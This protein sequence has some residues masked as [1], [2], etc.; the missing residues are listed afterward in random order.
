MDGTSHD[1]NLT[2]QGSNDG[3]VLDIA[4]LNQSA[5]QDTAFSYQVPANTFSDLDGDA[6]AYS[7]SLADGSSLPAWLGF[8]ASTGTLSG[9]PANSDVGS[10]SV[11]V[12]ASDGLASASSTFTL[13]VNNV[14]DVAV[15]SGTD[16]GAVTEDSAPSL[17]VSGTLNISD[18]DVGESQFN[19]GNYSGLYGSVTLDAAGAWSY[20]ASSSQAAIQALGDG[21]TLMDTITIQS[22]DGTNH[23]VTITINGT[24]DGAVISGNNLGTVSDNSS[25]QLAVSGALS[26][27]DADAGQDKFVGGTLNGSYGDLTID[28]NG[29]WQ[30]SASSIH[31]D[32][33]ALGDG[34]TVTETLTVQSLDGTS[35]DII[36][37]INGTNDAP[38]AS[39]AAPL[40]GQSV[41]QDA[42]FVYQLPAMAF[43]D[44]D[45]NDTLTY[46]AALPDGSPLPAWLNFDSLTR[47]FSGTPGSG[48]VGTIAVTV[49]ASDGVASATDT[50]NINVV[51]VDD[52]AV[53]GGIDSSFVTEDN[54]FDLNADGKLVASGTLTIS[55]P[56]S[57][58]EQFAAGNYAGQYGAITLDAAGNWEYSVDNSLSAVQELGD[59]DS[60]TD[61]IAI[62][63]VDGTSHNIRVDIY[64]NNDG[65]VISGPNSGMVS[66]NDA[67][68]LT[69]SGVLA[70]SDTDAGQDQFVSATTS[71]SYGDLT[72]D[73]SG[74]WQ[75][76]ADNSQPDIQG[77]ARDDTLVD[78]IAV[79]S[80]DGTRHDINVTI[81][82]VG[83]SPVVAILLDTAT[84]QEQVANSAVSDEQTEASVAAFPNGGHIVT[85][86]SDDS[87]QDVVMAQR[88]DA[89]GNP[90]GGEFQVSATLAS[91]SEEF[92]SPSVAVLDNG[93]FAVNWSHHESGSWTRD[94]V[95]FFSADGTALTSDQNYSQLNDQASEITALGGN[96]YAISLVDV[97]SDPNPIR[98]RIFDESGDPENNIVIANATSSQWTPPD[99]AALDNGGF[100]ITWREDRTASDS[101]QLQIFDASGNSVHGPV[102]FGGA[103]ASVDSNT[104]NLTKVIQLSDGTLATSYESDGTWYVQLWNNDGTMR[105]AAFAI[106]DSGTGVQLT[107]VGDGFMATFVA[108]DADGEGVY[109]RQFNN[110]GSVAGQPIQVNDTTTGNQQAP[111]ITELADGSVKVVWSGNQGGDSDI[112]Q[113][114]LMVGQQVVENTQPGTVVGQVYASDPDGDAVTFSLVDD[115]GG[116]FA[117]D[118]STGV[119]TAAVALDYEGA[120]SH[121]LQVRVTDATGAYSDEIAIISVAD[122]QEAAVIGGGDS[123][124][125]TEDSAASLTANGTL[126]INDPDSGESQFSAGNY[127]GL[128]GSVTL[129]AA[130]AWSYTA[131]S[132]QAAIQ[133]LGDGETL[134]DTITIQS[135]DGTNHD[136]TITING[137][138]DGAVIS[139]TNAGSAS[140]DDAVTLIISGALTISDAD[141]GQNQF[142]SASHNGNYGTLTI[143]A[144][145]NWQYSADNSQAV[146]QA[147]GV[148]DVLSETIT[149]Y[150]LDGTSH[151]INLS[152]QGSNDGPVLDIALLNQSATQ[153]TAFSYQVP[154]NTFSDLDGDALAYSASLADGSSLPA[155]L[156][157][158]ASTGTLSGTPGNSDVGSVSVTVTASD[159]LASASSTFTLSVNNVNDV[160][161]ISG[162]D[163][164]A[165]TEDS[166]PSLTV[167][168]TLSIS[169]PDVGES[170]FSAGNYSGLY[171]SVTLDAAGAWSYTASSSQA[172]IQA[173]GDGETLMDTITI[174]S[175]DGTNHDLTI[176][177]NGTNDGAVISGTDAGSASE[178]DAGTLIISGA[179]TI[180]DADAGQN[181]FASA[182]HNGNYG[183]LTI[184]A[185]GNWQYS[186]DNSQAVAYQKPSQSIRWTAPATIST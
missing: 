12:T 125:V 130:G 34:E 56:D 67:A 138:N 31:A 122:Q 20:T 5:T 74:N 81:K 145:G 150:S 172:A 179:L 98:V 77:L 136:V 157:F 16:V 62:Q 18:P 152:I 24:N 30:Y 131:S 128:Y 121:Q 50:F 177:I 83:G 53:I 49:T 132:S 87:G 165:V 75:Y 44:V 72:I 175:V 155:W 178:D 143:D 141:A 19:A 149:V 3:P 25:G 95:R 37:T 160:A 58:E 118:A 180:S 102:S 41:N 36:I 135:V 148:G 140:E 86:I 7:A 142:A 119:I 26:I 153:D 80:V 78:T 101:G 15:I 110:D 51:N 117:I 161:V 21:E 154:A 134:M 29:N 171:G 100:A 111:A 65:A 28:A 162:T 113:K 167:S 123:A 13:N 99:I 164:G 106:S 85:W 105:D 88:Y 166:A 173:L 70:I 151:D 61:I 52:P 144:N 68:M 97:A 27:T 57:G 126:S 17:T 40:A 84:D 48:N 38:F 11:T 76:S 182:S 109:I 71:G 2:I 4:L 103:P 64:G 139:G 147:L 91:G 23:D 169:D 43:D 39:S 96:R 124:S 174:Q 60:L 46:S 133:A 146:I 59:I 10:V 176:T 112:Y 82:G 66:E 22:V 14:N 6:L 92:Q 63:S 73:A 137:T 35:H 127:S 108:A 54:S 69:V 184:D 1:I 55:D 159:G 33:K 156:S 45:S 181:Q 93:N 89:A 47:T 42:S 129:D 90:E 107:A 120:N 9:T 186:A 168:G 32:I 185:N 115:A 114:T 116:R 79:Y 170:Q 158:D 183:T 104:H 8:D 94:K 163:A